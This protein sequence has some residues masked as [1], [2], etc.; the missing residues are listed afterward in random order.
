MPTLDK[1][2]TLLRP[3]RHRV[4]VLEDDDDIQAFSRITD[5]YPRSGRHVP[6]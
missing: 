3:V 5:C 1:D 2:F 4:T 6:A